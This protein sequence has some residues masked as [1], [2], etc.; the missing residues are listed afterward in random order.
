MHYGYMLASRHETVTGSGPRKDEDEG[1]W[2]KNASN[3]KLSLACGF[4]LLFFLVGILI[5]VIQ[6]RSTSPE[7]K[8]M[9]TTTVCVQQGK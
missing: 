5:L 8:G 2:S 4:M 7:I 1:V 9:C 6:L 3:P